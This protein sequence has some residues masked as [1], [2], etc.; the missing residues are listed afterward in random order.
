MFVNSDGDRWVTQQM[1]ASPGSSDAVNTR[2]VL[3]RVDELVDYIE[4]ENNTMVA[5]VD[6]GLYAM[7]NRK[8]RTS[9]DKGVWEAYITELDTWNDKVSGL[10]DGFRIIDTPLPL[11]PNV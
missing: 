8:L 7:A 11:E 1:R 10:V 5:Y 6:D 4:D 9:E 2:Y 3:D